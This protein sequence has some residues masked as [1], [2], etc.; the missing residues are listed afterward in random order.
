M[1][2]RI[3]SIAAVVLALCSTVAAQK[4]DP[5]AQKL[6]S[7]YEAAF[8]NAD[9]K[10]VAALYTA[11]AVRLGPDGQFITGRSAIEQSYV[12]GFAGPLKGAKLTLTPG[13]A[14]TVTPDVK[15]IEGTFSVAAAMP[16]KGRYVNTIVRQSGQWR[17]ASVT[18]RPDLAPPK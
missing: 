2:T 17:L 14:L 3:A 13:H 12:A 9:V 8:N 10:A 1:P 11:D 7:Q 15:V 16:I 6:A 5:D 4:A 18:T